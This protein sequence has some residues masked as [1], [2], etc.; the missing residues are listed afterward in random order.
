M[1]KQTSP[2]HDRLVGVIAGTLRQRGEQNV[3]AD[4]SGWARPQP[5]RWRGS[6]RSGS[7]RR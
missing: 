5:I 4:L 7:R 1:A 2:E 3:R 6:R